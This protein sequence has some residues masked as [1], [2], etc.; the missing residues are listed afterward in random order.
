MESVTEC[1]E[2]WIAE[3]NTNVVLVTTEGVDD[4]GERTYAE[5]SAGARKRLEEN[6][7]KY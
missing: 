4:K 7:I 5:E 3:S 6:G 2:G 1:C